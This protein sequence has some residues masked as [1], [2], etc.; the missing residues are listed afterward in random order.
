MSHIEWLLEQAINAGEGNWWWVAT[1]SD[2]ADIAFRRSDL[3]LK[4]F[5]D[6][7]GKLKQ[8]A[9]PIPHATNQTRKIITVNGASIWFK[10]AEKPDNLFGEDVRGGV[11][12]E[13]TRWRESAWQAFYT[14]LTATAGRAK[15]IG[16]VKGRHNFAYRL[17]RKAQAGEVGWS[18]HRLTADDA[19]A[20]GIID[21]DVLEQA[22]RDL[23]DSVYRELYYAEATEDGSNPF[24]IAAIKD[25][26]GELSSDPVVAWGID[27]GRKRDYTVAIGLDAFGRT[28][29]FHRWV[30]FPLWSKTEAELIKLIGNEPAFVDSTGIGDRVLEALQAK[31]PNVQ[32]YLFTA[33]SKQQLMELLEITIQSRAVQYPEGA[34]SIELESFE[35]EHTRTGVYY[36]APEGLHDDCVI[37]LGL[38]VHGLKEAGC[39][40]QVRDPRTFSAAS[41]SPDSM[42]DYGSLALGKNGF[43]SI[44]RLWLNSLTGKRHLVEVWRK[45]AHPADA[46]ANL[47][48]LHAK[49]AFEAI[50][51]DS[52]L[53]ESLES[54]ID[55]SALPFQVVDSEDASAVISSPLADGSLLVADHIVANGAVWSQLLNVQSDDDDVRLAVCNAAAMCMQV[56]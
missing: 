54:L 4:G 55:N 30:K 49:R 17:A 45:A 47:Q 27:L 14:T 46:L 3:R 13:V 36:S 9:S 22:S 7:G 11:G 53:Y 52:K 31:C 18:H 29:A 43:Y 16:N 8:I 38:A 56:F 41:L 35:F 26:I 34:I 37:S 50:G 39:T 51:I 1:T 32:G 21:K 25:C 48:R 28:A 24:G 44:A 12:D 19:V 6:S 23:N 42:T 2:T 15:L 33:K 10:T 40:Y 5:I 20:A